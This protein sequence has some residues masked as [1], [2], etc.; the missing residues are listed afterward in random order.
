MNIK[1]YSKG[2]AKKIQRLELAMMVRKIKQKN[3]LKGVSYA[4]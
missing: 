2:D 3:R 4:K 1:K